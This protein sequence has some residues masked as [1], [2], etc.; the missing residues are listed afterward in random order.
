LPLERRSI[1]DFVA[2][3]AGE[4]GPRRRVL[5]AGAGEAPYHELFDHCDYITTD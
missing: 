5:D 3:C 1:L 2:G 4:M